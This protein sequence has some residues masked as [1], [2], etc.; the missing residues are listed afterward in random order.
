[1]EWNRERFAVVVAALTLLVVALLVLQSRNNGRLPKMATE[2]SQLDVWKARFECD[3]DAVLMLSEVP[4]SNSQLEAS[5]LVEALCHER[6]ELS[7]A[8][9]RTIQ[10][11]MDEWQLYSATDCQ[12]KLEWLT[13]LLATAD[14]SRQV[15]SGRQATKLARSVLSSISLSYWVDPRQCRE[16]CQL[17]LRRAADFADATPATASKH[18]WGDVLAGELDIAIRPGHVT[19]TPDLPVENEFSL[20]GGGIPVE[21]A[22]GRPALQEPLR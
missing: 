3:E 4:S 14:F 15:H 20:P 17:V 6:G 12:E 10:G 19:P 8:A 18:P 13:Q 9:Y 16:N 2:S 11:R 5:V 21:S 7:V 22:F 1:M